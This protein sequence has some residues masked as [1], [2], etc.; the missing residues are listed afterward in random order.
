M[1]EL[2]SE[3][4]AQ[5]NEVRSNEA[6]E[7]LLLELR[8]Q[9][10]A[11][12]DRLGLNGGINYLAGYRRHAKELGLTDPQVIED[13]MRYGLMFPNFDQDEEFVSWMKRPVADSPEQRFEDYQHVME[14]VWKLRNTQWN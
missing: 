11:W 2:S 1:F 6:I 9:D 4:V 14:F 5:L 8:T 10:P 13:F 12:Y 3:Q 7:R